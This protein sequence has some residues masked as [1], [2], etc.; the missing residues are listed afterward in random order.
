MSNFTVCTYRNV[1]WCSRPVR[2][3]LGSGF[4]YLCQQNA[5][6][7]KMP[8]PK[9]NNNFRLQYNGDCDVLIVETT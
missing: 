7:I 3:A 2:G 8:A 4:K 9:H 1:V 6:N 5:I